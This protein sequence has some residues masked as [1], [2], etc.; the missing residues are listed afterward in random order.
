M[1]PRERETPETEAVVIPI[2]STALQGDLGR[3]DG[4][5]GLVLFAH[6]SGSSRHSS[7][8][9]Y[10][11]RTLEA[12]GLATLLVDLLTPE[13]ERIDVVTAQY[14][15]DLPLLAAR[16]VTIVDWLRGRADTGSLPIGSR[17]RHC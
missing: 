17:R 14:R 3:P 7:R 6:G 13:E 11:A 2:G 4:A 16:L 1:D 12:H 9:R 8:N 10:V 15:F 5:S